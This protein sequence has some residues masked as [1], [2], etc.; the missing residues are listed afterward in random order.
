MSSPFLI[1]LAVFLYGL[2]HSLLALPWAK[3]RARQWFGPAADRWYRLGYNLFGVISLLP[4]LALPALLPDQTLYTIPIPWTYLA[5]AGQAAAVV[6]LVVGVKQTGAW[7]FLGL[8]QAFAPEDQSPPR[9]VL[10]GL[11]RWVRHPLY[12]AGLLFIWLIPVMTANLLA[13]NIG[14]TIYLII[15]ALFEERK[16]V[17]EFGEVYIQ[18]RKVTPMLIPRPP[19][20]SILET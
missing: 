1:I 5:L 3:R 2:V 4:V 6:M 9:L 12:T 17:R 11:Y 7:K 19:R 18:Y 16:L 14:L 15:G 10:T 8:Q 20:S 13:L